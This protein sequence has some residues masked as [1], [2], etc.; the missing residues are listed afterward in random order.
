[1]KIVNYYEIKNENK[2]EKFKK[3]HRFFIK[4][5]L[6]HYYLF[7]CNYIHMYIMSL[8]TCIFFKIIHFITIFIL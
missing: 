4:Y 3:F 6:F 2:Y 8:S 1:M 5:Y 7:R